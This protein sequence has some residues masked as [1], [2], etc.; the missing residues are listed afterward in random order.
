MDE[1]PTLKRKKR[2]PRAVLMQR[3]FDKLR[4]EQPHRFVTSSDNILFVENVAH[5]L[6]C[7][8]DHVRRI[9]KSELPAAK[10]GKRST[11]LRSDVENYVRNLRSIEPLHPGSNAAVANVQDP[12]ETGFNPI[13]AVRDDQE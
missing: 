5:M 12:I 3:S 13:K 7:G 6:G 1:K 4:K 9:S 2:I 8:V 10:I 11:Y